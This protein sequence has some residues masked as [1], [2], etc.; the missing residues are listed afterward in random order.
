MPVPGRRPPPHRRV[1]QKVKIEQ[2][3]RASIEVA[4][5]GVEG[6]ALPVPELFRELIKKS[7]RSGGCADQTPCGTLAQVRAPSA[8][9]HC[10]A[11]LVRRLCSSILNGNTLQD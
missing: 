1:G 3:D 7:I 6:I 5:N 2:R 10:F 4:L 8:P 9:L 11:F